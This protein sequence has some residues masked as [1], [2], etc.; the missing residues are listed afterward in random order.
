MTISCGSGGRDG[1]GGAVEIAFYDDRN[2]RQG[3]GDPNTRFDVWY[4]YS[5]DVGESFTNA[6]L[7]KDPPDCEADDASLFFNYDF[8]LYRFVGIGEYL[9]IGSRGRKTIIV[10]NGTKG[11]SSYLDPEDYVIWGSTSTWP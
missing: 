6:E 5:T 8:G 10:F 1:G 7:C 3:D 11:S 9:G 2:W 4:A